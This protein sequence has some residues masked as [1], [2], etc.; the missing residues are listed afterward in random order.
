MKWRQ[1]H[2]IRS[3]YTQ[4]GKVL[5]T[6]THTHTWIT[7]ALME[8]VRCKLHGFIMLYYTVRKYSRMFKFVVCAMYIHSLDSIYE[9]FIY[10]GH[11]YLHALQFFVDVFFF[12]LLHFFIVSTS[13]LN[14]LFE[15][16]LGFVF[17]SF[18]L[19]ILRRFFFF[20]FFN[21]FHSSALFIAIVLLQWYCIVAHSLA[22]R[23]AFD[24]L[25]YAINYQFLLFRCCLHT[26]KKIC[27]KKKNI[28][29]LYSTHTATYTLARI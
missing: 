14:L 19:W 17:S 23:N 20:F 3:T 4:H 21:F 29:I 26:Q 2:K 22:S 10:Y 15:F 25:Q 18:P 28:T 1:R 13:S 24:L 27:I 5:H 11:I 9:F 7:I 12:S 8:I 16:F 6:H